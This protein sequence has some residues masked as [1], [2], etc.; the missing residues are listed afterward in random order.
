MST[1]HRRRPKAS[2]AKS[3]ATTQ[4]KPHALA[5]EPI[6]GVTIGSNEE[7]AIAHLPWL[8]M[9]VKLLEDNP[10]ELK[11]SWERLIGIAEMGEKALDVIVNLILCRKDFEGLGELLDMA[12]ARSLAT[13]EH[14]GLWVPEKSPA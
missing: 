3:H 14:M 2:T 11:Q 4:T 10:E 5:F 12:L 1:R 7:G 6:T 9:A 8:R 13:L